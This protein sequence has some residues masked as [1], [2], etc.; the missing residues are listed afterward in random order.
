MSIMIKGMKMPTNCSDCRLNYDCYRCSVIDGDKGYFYNDEDFEP[1]FNRLPDC[2]LV[3]LLTHGR[4]IDAD[5]AIS[6]YAKYGKSHFYDASDLEY[7]L[8]ECQTI[9]ESEK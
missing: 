4:L 8:A 9:I 3:E 5:K 1:L 6:D 2:P 7:I